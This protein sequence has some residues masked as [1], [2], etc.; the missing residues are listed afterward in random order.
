M[1]EYAHQLCA[2]VNVCKRFDLYASISMVTEVSD[3][4]NP[5]MQNSE[6]VLWW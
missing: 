6:T 5:D 2:L 1:H 3:T 4:R